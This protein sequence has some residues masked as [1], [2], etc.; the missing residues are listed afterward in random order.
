M[1]RLQDSLAA[2]LANAPGH[3]RKAAEVERAF[4]VDY[5]LGWQVHRIASEANPVAAGPHVPAR[6]SMQRLLKAAAR[7]GIPVGIVAEVAAA[8]EDFGA[9]VDAEA[10]DREE[11]DAMLGALAPEAREKQ[12]RATKEAAF[13]AQSQ[14]KGVTMEAQVGAFFL[15]PSKDGAMV[16][17]A[18]FSAYVG[19]R[20][21]RA[22]SYIGF[23]TVSSASSQS[24][25]LTLAGTPPDE[26]HS[27]LLERF[28]SK[29][30]PQ[31][32]TGRFGPMTSYSV[33]G[34]S[35][36]LR[37]AIDLVMAELR[38]GAM[39]RYVM[40]D[41]KRMTGVMNLPDIPMKRQVTDVF[42]HR[43]VYPGSPPD[44]A[45]FDTVPR[46][47]VAG[48]LSDPA[49]ERDRIRFQET[50]QTIV[51]GPARAQVACLPTY[52][53]MLDFVCATLG[54]DAAAFRGYR[55]DVE[56]PVYGAQYMIGF[57]LPERRA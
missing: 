37:S 4:G 51:G 19:L 10:H 43:E 28:C 30:V 11:L 44:F 8:F 54:W 47:M 35:V 2:L 24:Q 41:G 56:F 9:L 3:P 14:L 27:I 52:R 45:V 29:P 15:H 34:E 17:R 50:M 33:A 38:P 20:R 40:P 5:K 46:G 6:V 31:F 18:T 32:D 22:D 36:G 48:G 26:A 57:A 16:D 7:V 12:E 39:R 21:L 42:V 25:V 1:A 53:E 23:S 13:R 55:L 49:R